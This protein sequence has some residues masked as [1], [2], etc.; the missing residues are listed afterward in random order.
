MP[1]ARSATMSSSTPRCISWNITLEPPQIR[2][3]GSRGLLFHRAK[4]P[5]EA[6]AE[7]R[8]TRPAAALSARGRIDHA[9]AVI[10]VEG[11]HKLPRA[12]VRHAHGA[13][14]GRDRAGLGDALNELGFAGAH[15]G[16]ALPKDAKRQ[17]SVSTTLHSGKKA[18]RR[19][20]CTR[21]W[22]AVLRSK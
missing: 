22:P 7:R 21:R 18:A 10:A 4:H 6:A 13:R 15:G 1:T 3:N 5:H 16:R 11:L 9:F 8:D 17:T 14:G 20:S 2:G 12:P 19:R